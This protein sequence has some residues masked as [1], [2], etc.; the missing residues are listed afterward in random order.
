LL[1]VLQEAADLGF[2]GPGAVWDHVGHA[3]GFLAALR[4][5]ARVLDLGSG[6]GV[7]GLVLAAARPDAALV[8]LDASQTRTDFLKRAVGRLG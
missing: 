2:L 8:L 4:P 1:G 5:A 3:A 7:P 6:G